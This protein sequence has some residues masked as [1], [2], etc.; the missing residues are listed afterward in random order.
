M[1]QIIFDGGDHSLESI[2]RPAP[3]TRIGLRYR[4]LLN[5]KELGL[6]EEC[7]WNELINSDLLG[8]L[9]V[10]SLAANVVGASSEVEV[11]LAEVPGALVKLRHA[12]AE[13]EDADDV[14]LIDADFFTTDQRGAEDVIGT[15]DSFH[16]TAGNLFRWVI[17]DRLHAALDPSPIA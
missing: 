1:L 7:G 6:S 13:T 2:Y 10:P 15:L 3:Y 17:S 14:Y 11:G 4:N 16:T 8:I 5:R 9:G 12:L